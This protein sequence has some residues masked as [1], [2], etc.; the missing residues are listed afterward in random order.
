MHDDIAKGKPNKK[1]PTAYIYFIFFLMTTFVTRNKYTNGVLCT[2][3]DFNLTKFCQK[4]C[5]I[6]GISQRKVFATFE[7][8]KT[9]VK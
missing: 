9:E 5:E 7:E 1:L 2:V 3:G 6:E 8:L 4:G